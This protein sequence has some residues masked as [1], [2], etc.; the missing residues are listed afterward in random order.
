MLLSSNNAIVKDSINVRQLASSLPSTAC[1]DAV[2]MTRPTNRLDRQV[3]FD[4]AA[5]VSHL[6][7][8]HQSTTFLAVDEV[9]KFSSVCIVAGS[10]NNLWITA[11][12]MSLDDALYSFS[13]SSIWIDHDNFWLVQVR[14]ESTREQ[15]NESRFRFVRFWARV[16]DYKDTCGSTTPGYDCI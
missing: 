12:T 10:G 4:K 9:F 14:F 5:V 2:V 8:P 13:I 1:S 11:R 15:F 16:A 3:I 7:S 6:S